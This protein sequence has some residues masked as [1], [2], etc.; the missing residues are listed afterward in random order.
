MKSV[1]VVLVL[2][3]SMISTGLA[4]DLGTEAEKWEAKYKQLL[5]QRPDIRKKVE[6]GNATKEDVIQWMKKGGD[7]ERKKD[8]YYGWK[9]AA[10][11]PREFNQTQENTVYSGPQSGEKLPAFT[12]IGVTG[13]HKDK[14]YDPVARVKDKPQLLIFQ[15]Y[16]V[17][18]MK[19]LYLLA[20]VLDT[21]SS[22]SE[23]DLV[24]TAVFLGDDPSELAANEVADLIEATK[25][26]ETAYSQDGRD[27]PGAYG[28]DR[29]VAM[30]I[31][32]A[33]NGKVLHNF[34]FPQPMLYPDPHLVG[35]LAELVG[36]DQETIVNWLKEQEY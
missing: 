22:K 2:L 13:P 7:R 30:T 9:V 36:H 23:A 35:A 33:K 8:R 24:A 14:A 28:L 12:A 20:P 31:I 4:K 25:I 17:V 5:K 15:D 18:S 6:T 29:N 27:G 34:A 1:L 32:V 19:G 3:V 16:S 10:K 26:Y 11:D 21:I